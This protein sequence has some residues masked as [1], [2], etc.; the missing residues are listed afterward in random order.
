[1][2]VRAAGPDTIVFAWPGAI[3]VGYGPFTF[4]KDLGYLK[5]ENVTL[6]TLTL[7][8]SGVIIPQL[9]K[10]SVFTTFSTLDPLII[11]RQ[12]GKPD[13]DFR[14]VYNSSRNSIWEIS[15]LDSSPIRSVKDLAGKTVGGGALAF[16]GTP[17]A[18]AILK[19]VGVD[20]NS[21]QFVAVGTEQ[22]A[23]EALRTGKVDAL[24][25]FDISDAKMRLEGM[26]IRVLSFPPEFSGVSSHAFPVTNKM[27]HDL[28]AKFGRIAAEG[29]VACNANPVACLHSLWK[30]YPQMR[31]PGSDADALAQTLPILEV[32]L[33]NMLQWQP[34]EP[35]KFGVFSDKDWNTEIISLKAGGLI[36]TDPKLDSLYTN[37]FVDDFNR[38][39]VGAVVRRAKAYTGN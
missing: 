36:A 39:D 18:K 31:P 33:K 10:G 38:F 8:G 11:S 5:E 22:P 29:T 35:K 34:G 37:Q 32:R 27:I 21:V 28:V 19:Q 4:A 17:M 26:K 13:F 23:F 15:V 2:P 6:S 3:S 9:M 12:P 25:L 14:F 24:N 30:H 20:P 1:L 7:D 16:G